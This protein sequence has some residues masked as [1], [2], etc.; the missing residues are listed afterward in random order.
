[1]C[2]ALQA[3]RSPTEAACTASSVGPASRS[4]FLCHQLG[5]L[6]APCTLTRVNQFEHW[7]FCIHSVSTAGVSGG[8]LRR[9]LPDGELARAGGRKTGAGR[10]TLAW[11]PTGV[12][13]PFPTS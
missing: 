5:F 6:L 8:L 13:L 9:T 4:R 12:G 10:C 7:F 3:G 11:P 2:L 1:M